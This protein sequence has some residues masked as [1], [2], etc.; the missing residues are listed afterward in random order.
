VFTLAVGNMPSLRCFQLNS[1]PDIFQ[2]NPSEAS[3][4]RC[5][6]KAE[7]VIR[8]TLHAIV[9]IDKQFNTSTGTDIAVCCQY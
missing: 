3:S 5:K 9:A 7:E 1:S 4:V 6:Y 8:T 2:S